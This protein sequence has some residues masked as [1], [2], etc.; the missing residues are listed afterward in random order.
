MVDEYA[1]LHIVIE[2]IGRVLKTNKEVRNFEF[3]IMKEKQGEK[4]KCWIKANAVPIDITDLTPKAT[5][6]NGTYS[7]KSSAATNVVIKGVG[8]QDGDNVAGNCE[9]WVTV[10]SDSISTSVQNR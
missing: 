10:F 6:E 8:V 1:D 5:N 4:Y 7:I 3:F 2:L 9:V